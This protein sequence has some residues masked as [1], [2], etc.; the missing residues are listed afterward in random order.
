MQIKPPQTAR[1]PFGEDHMIGLDTAGLH[2]TFQPLAMIQ[3]RWLTAV[4][5][6]SFNRW[7]YMT[8]LHEYC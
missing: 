3:A 1:V 5:L 7:D 8:V 2:S 4:T 6:H